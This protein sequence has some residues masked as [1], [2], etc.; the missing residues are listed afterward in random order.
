MFFLEKESQIIILKFIKVSLERKTFYMH[1]N[2][3]IGNSDNVRKYK[4]P[5][6]R[7]SMIY[8]I[9][10]LQFLAGNH[11]TSRLRTIWDCSI[12]QMWRL[13]TETE[14]FDSNHPQRSPV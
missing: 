10:N 8:L 2:I 1:L 3:F 5:K 6:S 9:S 4:Y 11:V 12:V 14:E 7:K 13:D